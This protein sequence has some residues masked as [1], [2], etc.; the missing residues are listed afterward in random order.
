MSGEEARHE[1]IEADKKLQTTV[2]GQITNT[3]NRLK[4]ILSEATDE[5]VR[6]LLN[7]LETQNI[8]LRLQNLDQHFE[9]A[10]EKYIML[11]APKEDENEEN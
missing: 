10:H 2:K 4:A 1:A 9:S 11:H 7:H 8:F 5:T 6:P 3:V